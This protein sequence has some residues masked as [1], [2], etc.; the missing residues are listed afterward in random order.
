MSNPTKSLISN[1]HTLMSKNR[2][3]FPTQLEGFVNCGEPSGKY[4]NCS[5]AFTM[6]PDV[7]SEADQDRKELMKWVNSVITGRVAEN[8][9]KWDESGLVKYSFD[10]D[11]GRPRPVFIDA[12]GDSLSLQTLKSIQKGTKVKIACQQ[13]PYTKPNKGTTLKVLGVQVVKLVTRNGASDSGS[14][15]ESDVV[16]LFGSTDGFRQDQPSVRQTEFN[17]KL[18]DDE[19]DF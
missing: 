14:L 17:S 15:S 9:P 18:T 16:E 7:V 6:P 11:S 5:F 19:Y 3:V 10:G 2:Y 1:P 12:L 13:V 4:N 8:L